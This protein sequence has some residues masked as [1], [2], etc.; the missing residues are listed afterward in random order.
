MGGETT[1][2]YYILAN[3]NPSIRNGLSLFE[4]MVNCSL[5]KNKYYW[6]LPLL[7]VTFQNLMVVEATSNM[8]HNTWKNQVG[9]VPK[10]SSLLSRFSRAERC[11]PVY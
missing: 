6:L 2:A 4:L 7:L 3:K 11:N 9:P 8:N 5:I 1:T 10:A